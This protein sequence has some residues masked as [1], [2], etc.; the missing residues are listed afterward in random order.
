MLLEEDLFSSE[1][2]QGTGY[3]YDYVRNVLLDAGFCDIEIVDSFQISL[4]YDIFTHDVSDNSVLTI[5]GGEQISLNVLA[6][7]CDEKS[8]LY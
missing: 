3:S 6:K 5:E 1:K 8:G 2:Y 7:I 4:N